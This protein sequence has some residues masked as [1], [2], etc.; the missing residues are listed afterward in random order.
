M[1]QP[2]SERPAS[3]SRPARRSFVEFALPAS[4]A[5]VEMPSA[6]RPLPTV[7]LALATRRNKQPFK[8]S[9]KT[10]NKIMQPLN[11]D[12][13]VAASG[14]RQTNNLDDAMLEDDAISHQ[15]VVMTSAAAKAAKDYRSWMLEHM[16]INICAALD[17]ANGLAS[18]N[19]RTDLV[20]R[21]DTREQGKNT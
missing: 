10:R 3:A 16:K 11:E 1:D 9:D 8:T 4:G 15:F 6:A 17:Y 14:L 20:A 19:S 18:V 21:P 2:Q 12:Q 7:Q 5:L 13:K